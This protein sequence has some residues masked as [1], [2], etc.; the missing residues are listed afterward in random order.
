MTIRFVIVCDMRV[1]VVILAGGTGSRMKTDIPKQFV[2]VDGVPVIVETIRSFQKNERVEGITVVCLK[3][4][5][6]YLGN[7]I[8]QYKLDKVINTVE[9]GATGHDSTRNG[10]YS[11]A[12]RMEKDDIVVIHDAARPL[13]PQVIINDMLDTAIKNGN[14]CTAI[15]VNDTVIVTDDQRS[16]DTQIERSRIMRVQTPQAYRYGLIKSLYRRAD[17]EGKH[18]FVY[19][20]T[21]AITYGERIFFSAGFDCNI[22]LTT[23]EDLAFYKVMKQF[24]EEE[25]TK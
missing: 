15:P 25:L 18:D 13:I 20:N 16:G 8:Q 6:S 11:L 5:I 7:L 17:V 19:A 10:V 1:E 4:W 14:A 22:K 9:G 3:D 21:M 2:K 12:E 24:S 23:K